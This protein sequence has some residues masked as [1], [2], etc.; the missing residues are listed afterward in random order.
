[1][2]GP[3]CYYGYFWLLLFSSEV[4]LSNIGTLIVQLIYI[5]IYMCVC[6]CVCVCVRACVCVWQTAIKKPRPEDQKITGL[7]CSFLKIN[8]LKYF[9]KF[10]SLLPLAK[11]FY[12]GYKYPPTNESAYYPEAVK[13]FKSKGI[14]IVSSHVTLG[15]FDSQVQWLPLL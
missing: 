12:E 11:K 3:V 1:M 6:V 8:R 5:C 2:C 10:T 9:L 7:R 13:P 14:K 4:F 15:A